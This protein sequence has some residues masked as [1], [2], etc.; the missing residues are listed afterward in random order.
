MS[1]YPPALRSRT[2]TGARAGQ[3]R[4]ERPGWRVCVS[5]GHPRWRPLRQEVSWGRSKGTSSQLALQ[6]CLGS[7]P[8]RR[9]E[10]VAG[11]GTSHRHFVRQRGRS[12]RLAAI[13]AVRRRH[14]RPDGFGAAHGSERHASDPRLRLGGRQRLLRHRPHQP[15]GAARA[16]SGRPWGGDPVLDPGPAPVVLERQSGLGAARD[17]VPGRA[18]AAA[19]GSRRRPPA[20]T[21]FT[22]SSSGSFISRQRE[23]NGLSTRSHASRATG[24]SSPFSR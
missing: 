3:T 21:R 10:C 7:R 9:Q 12:G 15:R 18:L 8:P 11:H 19:L 23:T 6:R 24:S 1:I 22:T 5:C 20:R 4:A 17:R 16:E 2:W 13:E 14:G